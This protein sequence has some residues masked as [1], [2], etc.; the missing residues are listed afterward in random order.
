[1]N[2]IFVPIISCPSSPSERGP[3]SHFVSCNKE[4]QGYTSAHSTTS[5]AD[6]TRM[7]V[8]GRILIIRLED[9]QDRLRGDVPNYITLEKQFTHHTL[10]HTV[11]L[12]NLRQLQRTRRTGKQKAH[13]DENRIV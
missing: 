8:E 10:V 12:A 11:E 13:D 5:S 4:E 7:S 3:E 9:C 1:M 6:I 2:T